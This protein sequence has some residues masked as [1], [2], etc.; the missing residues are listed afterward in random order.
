M[1]DGWESTEVPS[2]SLLVSP[3]YKTITTSIKTSKWT[4]VQ[5]KTDLF[6]PLSVLHAPVYVYVRTL[7][8]SFITGKELTD[9]HH[10]PDKDLLSHF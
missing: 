7:L 1:G 10:S 8:C 5:T 6:Q 4:L 3:N 9:H 2:T